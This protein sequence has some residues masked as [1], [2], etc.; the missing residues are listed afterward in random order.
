MK[1][2][3]MYVTSKKWPRERERD[4]KELKAP[5]TKHT[6]LNWPLGRHTPLVAITIEKTKKK[7]NKKPIMEKEYYSFQRFCW[8]VEVED[9]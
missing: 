5:L 2:G 9:R 7:N 4:G 3:T 6:R 1:T 8:L